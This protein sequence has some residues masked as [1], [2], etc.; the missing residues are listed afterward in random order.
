MLEEDTH[1]TLVMRAWI[2][3][4]LLSLDL[5]PGQLGRYLPVFRIAIHET[6]NQCPHNIDT[7]ENWIGA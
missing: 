5:D 6:P 4:P 7:A 3:D 2:L 1:R